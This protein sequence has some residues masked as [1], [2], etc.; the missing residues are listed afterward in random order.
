MSRQLAP[1]ISTKGKGPTAFQAYAKFDKSLPS[2][3]P[4]FI[5]NSI[6]TDTYANVTTSN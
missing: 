5:I 6:Q 1:T 4:R 3:M 2:F